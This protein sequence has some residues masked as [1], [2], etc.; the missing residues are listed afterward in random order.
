MNHTRKFCDFLGMFELVYF[1]V[2]V[3][4]CPTRARADSYGF[5]IPLTNDE[6]IAE[7][8]LKYRGRRGEKVREIYEALKNSPLKAKYPFTLEL[9]YLINPLI[10]PD[11]FTARFKN[12]LILEWTIDDSIVEVKVH[13]SPDAKQMEEWE[14]AIQACVF[15]L[16][17]KHS[18]FPFDYLGG[19]EHIGLEESFGENSLLFRDFL[20]YHLSHPEIGMG[21]R[22]VKTKVARSVADRNAG[23]IQAVESIFREFDSLPPS[24]RWTIDEFIDQLAARAPFFRDKHQDVFKESEIYFPKDLNTM[25]IRSGG[26]FRNAHEITLRAKFRSAIKTFLLERELTTGKPLPLTIP[27]TPVEFP[28]VISRFLEI[29]REVKLPLPM[30]SNLIQLPPQAISRQQCLMEL[31]LIGLF[32]ENIWNSPSTAAP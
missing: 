23:E 11:S 12:G 1:L 9:P 30:F 32:P 2:A 3:F 27:R 6:L 29:L 21:L 25:E 20:A 17:A 22:G 26:P 16:G 24:E 19:H 8:N 14:P 10:E 31:Y 7:M 18:I 13:G 4:Q 28:E 15:D 5:E